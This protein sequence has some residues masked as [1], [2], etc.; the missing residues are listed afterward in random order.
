MQVGI[1]ERSSACITGSQITSHKKG[2][3]L[4]SVSA[5]PSGNDL[6]ADQAQLLVVVQD[7]IHA[8]EACHSTHPL[9]SNNR[10]PRPYRISQLRSSI[11]RASTGPSNMTWAIQLSTNTR[12]SLSPTHLQVLPKNVVFPLSYLGANPTHWPSAQELR[13]MSV[14][15][16]RAISCFQRALAI[17]PW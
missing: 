7:C 10:T 9:G 1:A 4:I 5:R 15:S 17:L 2:I 13:G 12:I 3:S 16:L 11:Q 8:P 14:S 6:A